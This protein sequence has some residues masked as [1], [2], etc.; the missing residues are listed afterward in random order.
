MRLHSLNLSPSVRIFA[1]LLLCSVLLINRSGYA[2]DDNRLNTPS[3]VSVPI[4]SL[5]RKANTLCETNRYDDALIVAN[6]ALLTA[7]ESGNDAEL[8]AVN[9][10]ICHIYLA[11]DLVYESLEY[12]YEGLKLALNRRDSVETGCY[13][14]TI[15]WAEE[16]LGHFSE[17]MAVNLRAL[18]FFR[19]LPDADSLALA[20]IYRIQGKIHAEMGNY[21][22]AQR[23]LN[24]A[25]AIYQANADTLNSSIAYRNLAFLNLK[26]SDFD[27]AE[28]YLKK[29]FRELNGKQNKRHLLRTKRIEAEL[30]LKQHHTSEAVN[31]LQEILKEQQA[32]D[33]TYGA[34]KT[35]YSLGTGYRMRMQFDRAVTHFSRC[36]NLADKIGLVNYRKECF[37]QL[38]AI[39]GKRGDLAGAYAFLRRYV[40]ITDSLYNMQKISE[41]N[42][43]ESQAEM[44]MQERK[45]RAQKELLIV[46]TNAL[47]QEAIRRNFLIVVLVLALGVIV[48]AFR[49]YR[50]KQRANLLLMEQK[51]EI[52]KQKKVLEHRTR[53]ITDSLNY[54]SRIQK[55]VLQ[56]SMQPDEFFDDSFLIFIPKELVSGDFY[57][58]KL[59]DSR[60]LLFAIADC[61]GHGAPGAF[62]SIIG[63]FGLNQ[64]VMEYGETNPAGVLDRLNDLF[65]SSFEQREGAEIFD[66]MDI[67]F[68]NYNPETKEL[69]YAGANIYLHIIRRTSEPPPS[70]II[71]NNSGDYTLYQVKCE[72]QSIGYLA[73]RRC[74]TTHSIQLQSGDIIYLFTDGFTDQFGGPRGKKFKLT[75]FRRILCENAELPLEKQR[76]ILLDLYSSWK[77]D[78]IQVDDVTVLGIRIS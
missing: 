29:A 46:K 22:R 50:L 19:S 40:A 32:I 68:C 56:V 11:N 15:S 61:T 9:R 42:R 55:A 65:N 75:D 44:R 10:L 59:I 16:Y 43:L 47:K 54:A 39:H 57:W 58:F 24:W 35:L 60:Q 30:M 36:L 5:I 77:G 14:R 3:A 73:G 78:N 70:S 72:R 13:Y 51:S 7:K 18:E 45:I 23:Y 1:L 25:V 52:E 21:Q 34:L 62:M 28:L 17:A 27:A 64:T 63:T 37:K 38:A 2:G 12:L 8:A 33:D 20:D 74:F 4:D 67:G 6:Q 26:R 71:L 69:K 41:A 31:L 66:G 48:F 76:N 49:E 53:D